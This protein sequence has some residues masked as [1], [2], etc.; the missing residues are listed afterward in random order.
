M[1]DAIEPSV[2]DFKRK[3]EAAWLEHAVNFHE[4]AVL[5]FAQAQVMQDENGDRRGEGAIGK[6]QSRRIALDNSAACFVFLR[7]PGGE[8]TVVFE[9]GYARN[10]FSQLGSG[11]ACPCS[12]FQEMIAQIGAA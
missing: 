12:D 5:Q 8:F 4:S 9:T 10:A 7:K 6:W 3:K 2:W 1:N 11:R